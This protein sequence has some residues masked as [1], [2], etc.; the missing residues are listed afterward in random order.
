MHKE[1]NNGWGG[2]RDRA[3]RRWNSPPPGVAQA[4]GNPV[5]T[6]RTTRPATHAA[7]SRTD[8]SSLPPAAFFGPY[9]THRPVP[10]GNPIPMQTGRASFWSDIGASRAE[11]ATATAI[12]S[13]NSGYSVQTATHP[14][15]SAVDFTQLNEQLNY[16]EENDEHADIAADDRII[17]ES[18]VDDIADNSESIGA[19]AEAE[20]QSSE[21]ADHSVLQ[22]QLVDLAKRLSDEEQEYGKPLCYLRGDFFDRPPH[23]VFALQTGKDTTGLDPDQLY[24]RKVFV[25]LPYLLP[26]HPDRFKCTCGMQLSKNGF[27][28]NPIAR[29]VWDMLSDFF[30]LTNRFV[31]DARRVN[32]P[33]CGTNF[34]G[35][36]PH[37]ISQLPRFVQAAFPAYISTWAVP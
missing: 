34:Q 2:S 9:N 12:D 19:A 1:D 32:S 36:D 28:D 16:I 15:I 7:V 8:G 37:I 35:T 27:N 4:I 26:G 10:R 29:R 25:W 31:C 24:L 6:T 33:G 14:N 5:H 13:T 11:A 23:P 18:L 20:T 17:D 3:G 30:L 21:P 22:K